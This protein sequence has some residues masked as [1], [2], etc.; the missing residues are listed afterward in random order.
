MDK[1]NLISTNMQIIENDNDWE[2]NLCPLFMLVSWQH[3][4]VLQDRWTWTQHD[5]LIVCTYLRWTQPES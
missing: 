2:Y 4:C 5:K 1:W 3:K